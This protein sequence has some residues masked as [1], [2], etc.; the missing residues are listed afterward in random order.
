MRDVRDGALL[1]VHARWRLAVYAM[2]GRVRC[3]VQRGEGITNQ[4]PC[5]KCRRLTLGRT[6]VRKNVTLP[7]CHRCQRGFYMRANVKVALS[8]EQEH[9]RRRSI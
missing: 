8:D 7:T 3:C 4:Q 1:A 6:R 5:H 9:Q 2:Q